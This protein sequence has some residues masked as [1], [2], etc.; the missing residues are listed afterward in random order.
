MV[1]VAVEKMY[2][3]REDKP[4]GGRPA[5]GEEKPHANLREV[6]AKARESATKAAAALNVSPRLVQDAKRV[7]VSPPRTIGGFPASA[8]AVERPQDRGGLRGVEHAR[9]FGAQQGICQR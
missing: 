9:L 2:A 3:A 8:V 6:S 1:A 7:D 4:K 5:K